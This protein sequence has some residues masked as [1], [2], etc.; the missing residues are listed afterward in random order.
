MEPKPAAWLHR[1]DDTSVILE[2][3]KHFIHPVAGKK[4]ES[5]SA[6]IY[7]SS[8]RRGWEKAKWARQVLQSP[9]KKLL[10]CGLAVGSRLESSCVNQKCRL[11][12]SD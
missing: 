1:K 12:G 6:R 5:H 11:L 10:A 4:D 9:R 8:R 2:F 3:C 7:I